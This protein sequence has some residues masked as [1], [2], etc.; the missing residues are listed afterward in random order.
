MRLP[1]SFLSVPVRPSFP[2]PAHSC[3]TSSVLRSVEDRGLFLVGAVAVAADAAGF[4]RPVALVGFLLRGV[5]RQSSGP[6]LGG[7]RL[8]TR[9][10]TYGLGHLLARPF[11]CGR[12]LP[13]RRVWHRPSPCT[14]CWAGVGASFCGFDPHAPHICPRC[15]CPFTFPFRLP[16]LTRT[17]RSHRQ[18][19]IGAFNGIFPSRHCFALGRVCAFSSFDGLT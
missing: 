17:P 8:D 13:A 4:A 14:C 11:D 9:S 2:P 18:L 16:L 7:W 10:S 3:R 5:L 6:F 1:N 15:V 19:L 12:A